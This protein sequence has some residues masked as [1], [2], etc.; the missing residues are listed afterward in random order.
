MAKI[1]A[2]WVNQKKQW[3]VQIKD[4]GT[5]KARR[6]ELDEPIPGGSGITSLTAGLGLLGGTI[7]TTG[8]IDVDFGDTEDQVARGN[9]YHDTRYY[10]I[11]Q[12]DNLLDT[13]TLPA[14]DVTILDAGDYYTSNNVEGALQEIGYAIATEQGV[15]EIDI[16]FSKENRGIVNILPT[17][18]R[19]AKIDRGSWLNN[20]IPTVHVLSAPAFSTDADSRLHILDEKSFSTYIAGLLGR[21]KFGQNPEAA[22][23]YSYQD[24]YH[25]LVDD[26]ILMLIGNVTYQNQTNVRIASINRSP[27]SDISHIKE[28]T[29]GFGINR[30]NIYDFSAPLSKFPVKALMDGPFDNGWWDLDIC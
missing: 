6:L 5:L 26:T 23:L 25:L 11:A 4:D 3:L 27:F 2:N 19:V 30:S 10:T 24:N 15:G 29:T 28:E 22:M 14:E 7:T 13:Y 17:S 16:V 9:H 8:T 18:K 12:I 21:N 20:R 1:V